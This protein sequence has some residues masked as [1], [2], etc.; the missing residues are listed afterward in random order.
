[1]FHHLFAPA[2]VSADADPEK[3]W[4]QWLTLTIQNTP[5]GG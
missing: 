3:A 1:M 5:Q 4:R 2:A